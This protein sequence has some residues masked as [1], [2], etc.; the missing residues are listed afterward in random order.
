MRHLVTGGSGFVG[1]HLIEALLREGHEVVVLDLVPLDQQL[2]RHPRVRYIQGDIRHRDVV[3]AATAGVDV[4]HHNAAILP[5]RR[6]GEELWDV[7]VHG[8]KTVLD[9]A[10][11][12]GVRKAIV[13]SS[14]SV[15][16]IQDG[17]LLNDD[18]PHR[19]IDSYGES[20]SACEDVCKHFRTQ[21]ALDVSIVRPCPIIGTGRMGIFGI[22]FD[23]IAAGKR[24]YVLGSGTNPY[25]FVSVDDLASMC[26]LLARVPA[27]NQDFNAGA[28]SFGTSAGDLRSLISHAGTRARVFCIPAVPA[29]IALQCLDFLHL[30]PLVRYHYMTADKPHCVSIEKAQRILDWQPKESNEAMLIRTYD[31]YM[32]HRQDSSLLQASAHRRPLHQ[33]ILRLLRFFS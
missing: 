1:T 14:S 4:V 32:A 27:H 11:H 33:G 13:V 29:R 24:V 8:T 9:A 23:W 25:Q 26:V 22:L 16:G 21:H 10:L 5:L 12:H 15:F 18:A 30:S 31:W 6:P 17:H 19:P 28:A 3:F 2:L 20:K 7:N